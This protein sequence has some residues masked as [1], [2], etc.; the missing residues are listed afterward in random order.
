MKSKRI[1]I[2]VFCLLCILMASPFFLV[3]EYLECKDLAEL[4]INC[5]N[6]SRDGCDASRNQQ[7]VITCLAGESLD[8]DA[9][10]I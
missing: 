9:D 8:C 10:P 4:E 3:A 5:K 1:Q 6:T 2:L 7:C